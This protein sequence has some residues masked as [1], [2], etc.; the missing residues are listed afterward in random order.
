MLPLGVRNTTAIFHFLGEESDNFRNALGH[1]EP[2][3]PKEKKRI[4]SRVIIEDFENV[5]LSP[6]AW[7][8]FEP[9]RQNRITEH[10][11]QSIKASDLRRLPEVKGQELL[12][13]FID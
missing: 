12:N 11:M 10:Y 5:T 3:S 1:L 2:A 6:R 9:E 7:N 8:Y 13:F 4:L